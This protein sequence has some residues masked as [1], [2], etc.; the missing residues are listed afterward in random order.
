[1]YLKRVAFFAG[2]HF[3]KATLKPLTV[4]CTI[5]FLEVCEYEVTALIS[6]IRDNI[7]HAR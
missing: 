7:I 6:R 2:S 1:M 4:Y 5:P 3:T